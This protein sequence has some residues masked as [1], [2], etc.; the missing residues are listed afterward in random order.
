MTQ[1]TITSHHKIISLQNSPA[2]SKHTQTL[3]KITKLKDLL[4]LLAL[5]KIHDSS[6]EEL[7]T[8]QK[9]EDLLQS[10]GHQEIYRG[11]YIRKIAVALSVILDSIKFPENQT[12]QNKI[13][14][15]LKSLSHKPFSR[16]NFRKMCGNLR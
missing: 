10:K 11:S 2:A 9:L 4:P 15:M 16:V 3:D 14:Q 6:D 12:L 13:L 5:E 8:I 1:K 7:Q